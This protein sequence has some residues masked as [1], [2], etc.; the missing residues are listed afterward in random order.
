MDDGLRSRWDSPE[1]VLLA[2]EVLDRLRAGQPLGGLGLGEMAGRVDLRGFPMPQPSPL[3]REAARRGLAAIRAGTMDPAEGLG[4]LERV[5]LVGVTLRG[6]DLSGA[7]LDKVTI[8]DC[9]VEDCVLDE[10]H[11]HRLGIAWSRVRDTSFRDA[12]LRDGGLGSWRDGTGPEFDR[13]DFSGA[14]LREWGQVTARFGDCDFSGARLDE[15]NFVRCG[16]VRCRFSGVLQEVLFYGGR[17]AGDDEAPDHVE[18]V[19]MSGA[20]FRHVSFRGFDVDSVRLPDDPALRVVR[21]WPDVVRVAIGMLEG[22]EDKY[23]NFLRCWL[24]DRLRGIDLGR[25]VTVL[26]RNDFAG[27]AGGNEELAVLADSVIRQA[28]RACGS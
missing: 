22:R 4:R 17:P 9:V 15:C 28:E 12:D 7:L 8:R 24:T 18:D 25:P 1:G 23:G 27:Y 11:G 10:V 5:E 21:Q 2:G 13:V 20:V 3:A 19:D 14:D 26:N 16:L 6:L